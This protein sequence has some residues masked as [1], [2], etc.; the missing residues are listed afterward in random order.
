MYSR[1]PIHAS[2][3]VVSRRRRS[4]MLTFRASPLGRP[5]KYG[6][7]HP[8]FPNS[9]S[10]AQRSVHAGVQK[11]NFLSVQLTERIAS[12]AAVGERSGI[13]MNE[14][15]GPSRACRMQFQRLGK[16]R[17]MKAGVGQRFFC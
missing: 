15:A 6:T 12:P 14:N 7:P 16:N 3:I 1:S 8:S 11:S 13:A 4:A 10:P 17:I 9:S 5:A 2:V